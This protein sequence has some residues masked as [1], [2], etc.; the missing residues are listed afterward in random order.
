MENTRHKTCF[1][2][3]PISSEGS[4]IRRHIDGIIDAV[5]VP[6]IEEMFNYKMVVSHRIDEPGNI[7]KQVISSIYESDLVIANL[8]GTNPNV[9]Y[10]LALSHCFGKI[11][12]IIADNDTKIPADIIGERCI[13][14][15]NDAKGVIELREKLSRMVTVIEN[16]GVTEK[17]GPVYDAIGTKMTSEGSLEKRVG[18]MEDCFDALLGGIG[19]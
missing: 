1:V 10:E 19:R 2:I 7:P 3:T 16:N 8:T 5:I 11:T 4:E 6:V 14:Y 13:F 17:E 9:M 18:F 12:I 15:I